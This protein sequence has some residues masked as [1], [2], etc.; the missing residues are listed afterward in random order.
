MSNVMNRKMFRPR[1]ARNKLN[2]MGGIMASSPELM[3]TVQRFSTGGQPRLGGGPVVNRPALGSNLSL[4]NID[5]Y[6][7]GILGTLSRYFMPPQ[8][9]N[10][11][12]IED[13]I[14][15]QQQALP[16]PA[17][18]LSDTFVPDAG[19]PDADSFAGRDDEDP[20]AG[21]VG[22][23]SILG[24]PDL[25]KAGADEEIDDTAT[26]TSTGPKE[27]FTDDED[28]YAEQ[29][30]T[31]SKTPDP[32]VTE[33]IN[34]S[35]SKAAM[36]VAQVNTKDPASVQTASRDIGKMLTD[37]LKNGDVDSAE[38][39]AASAIGADEAASME[40]ESTEE[41][42]MKQREIISKVLGVDPKEYE[43][44]KGL[45]LANF[46]FSLMT[47]S[48]GESAQGLVAE[49]KAN[50]AAKQAREDKISAS[51]ISTIL[52]RE[53]KESDRNFIRETKQLDRAHDWKKLK[54]TEAGKL[55]RLGADMNFR[56]FINDT[57]NTL[58]LKIKNL[59]VESLNAKMK[60]DFSMLAQR[61]AS[62]ERIAN[63]K[64]I[65]DD[66]RNTA[67][68]ESQKYRAILSGLGDGVKFAFIEGEQKG[69]E[70]E[71]L[72]DFISKRSKELAET[73][74]SLTGPDSLK[75]AVITLAPTIMKEDGV[76]FDE[77]VQQIINSDEAQQIFASD[78]TG[79]GINTNPNNVGGGYT[80][81]QIVTQNGT[82][83]EVTE[84]DENGS[85]KN[86]KPVAN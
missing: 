49:L 34:P 61:I 84:I 74:S 7:R 36:T 14:L 64:E 75:R 59:D 8:T 71:K 33:Q 19:A 23:F 28:A 32:G 55:Q 80:I 70:G 10:V 83:Y 66:R 35:A 31:Q 85:I 38:D 79:L 3:G 46:G 73:T 21:D 67:L 50:N 68:I 47:K 40:A 62:A 1:N 6:G 51:A 9:Q 27:T 42:I 81:G 63:Q 72:N 56:A 48:I 53:E 12:A 43:K 86:A 16:V 4:P 17:P 24:D 54:T 29:A 30:A 2:Q 45:A 78:F 26:V 41:R 76:G 52:G 60:N 5:P 15:N 37:F 57:N 13:V 82:K 11:A 44:N 58:K 25:A 39:V 20:L 69:L 77:A 22:R 65:G 18:R